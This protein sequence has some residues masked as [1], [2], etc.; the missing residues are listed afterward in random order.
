MVIGYYPNFIFIGEC[1]QNEKFSQ[2]HINLTK[3]GII[4][5][6]YTLPIVL[7]EVLG[8]KIQHDGKIDQV[9][10]SDITIIKDWYNENYNDLPQGS[11]L[12]QSSC[13]QVWPYPAL[14][15]GRGNWSAVDLLFSLPE[16]PMTFMDE[17]DGE[18]FRVQIT[19]VYESK[20]NKSSNDNNSS[21]RIKTRSK[22]LLKLIES[23]EQEKKER[24]QE[25]NK[26]PISRTSSFANF[27]DYIPQ[28]NLNES[29]TSLINLS[30]IALSQSR[31]MENKQMNLIKSLGPEQGF[32]LTKIHFHYDHH[33]KMRNKHICLRQGKIIYLKALDNKGQTHPGVLAFARQTK[34]E[35]GIFAINFREHESNFLL[36]LKPLVGDDSNF[37]TICSIQNW[38]NND[39]NEYYFLRELTQG[40]NK[41]KIGPFQSV[42]FGFELLPFSQDV[43]KKTMEQSNS[44]MINEIKRS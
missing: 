33:R 12:I 17:I 16:I 1:W 20:D 21:G 30:G 6:L 27:Q 37:D 7:C 32:D 39:K 4:P 3:S 29:I 43:Y 23:K 9:P 8:K 34:E 25:G 38:D 22:S 19:S 10:P 18:A 15:Y 41:R 24:E 13:G 26:K 42:C 2:R 5:R 44:I 28:Y 36:D 11:L 35:T 31:D 14:L 40:R